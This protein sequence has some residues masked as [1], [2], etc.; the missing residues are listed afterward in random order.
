MST[1]LAVMP[2]EELIEILRG[3]VQEEVSKKIDPLLN[4]IVVQQKDA[5]DAFDVC[6][7]TVRKKAN[8]GEINILQRDGSRLNYVT[9]SQMN[10]L[11]SRS[12]R[13]RK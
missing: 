9:I 10:G 8:A 1:E 11:K 6:D 4:V 12:R 3:I 7:D 2:K 13:V 5:C